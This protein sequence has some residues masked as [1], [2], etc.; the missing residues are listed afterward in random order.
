MILL[1]LP[2]KNDSGHKVLKSGELMKNS[3]EIRP[4]M[5]MPDGIFVFKNP[6]LGKF[7]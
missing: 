4:G 2:P 5:P 3:G 6:N 7:W 1:T